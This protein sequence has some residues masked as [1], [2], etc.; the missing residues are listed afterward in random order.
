[1][2]CYFLAFEDDYATDEGSTRCWVTLLPLSAGGAWVDYVY[3]LVSLETAPVKGAKA[4]EKPAKVVADDSGIPGVVAFDSQGWPISSGAPGADSLPHDHASGPIAYSVTP[5][6]GGDHNA[7]W[8]NCGVYSQPV[9]SERAVHNLEHGA[10][11]I[12]YRPDLPAAGVEALKAFVRRQ[13]L[14]VLSVKGQMVD[15][16]QRY[17]DLSPFPGLPA[18]IVISSWAHQLRV[19]SP[20]DPRLGQFVETFRVSP[21]YSPEYGPTCQNQPPALGGVPEFS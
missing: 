9:P 7:K 6:M 5:P 14:V 2:T 10:V 21:K 16:H 1:M 8:M 3:A 15:T 12:T 20:G 13:L 17:I 19:R 4:V 11:W 18:P